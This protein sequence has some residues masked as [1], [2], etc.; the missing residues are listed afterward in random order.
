VAAGTPRI[1]GA[2]AAW[3]IALF[4]AFL[5]LLA[6]G[7]DN[8]TVD[9]AVWIGIFSDVEGLAI[10]VVLAQWRN[11]IPTLARALGMRHK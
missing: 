3:G 4:A 11:D 2:G 7:T 9:A 6:F 10:S 1:P 8:A 5:S